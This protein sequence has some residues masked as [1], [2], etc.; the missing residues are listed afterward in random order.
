MCPA[1]LTVEHHVCSF[2][3][4]PGEICCSKFRCLESLQNRNFVQDEPCCSTDVPV[5][6]SA[7]GLD[8]GHY[9]I[10]NECIDLLSPTERPIHMEELASE[11]RVSPPATHSWFSA[12]TSMSP[13]QFQN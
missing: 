4:A 10:P 13:L 7:Q 5:R 9:W 12:V 6:H 11:V 8:P 1:M 2:M 3:L